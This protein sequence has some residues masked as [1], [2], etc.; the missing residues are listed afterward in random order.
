M[1]FV[2][3][4]KYIVCYHIL[5]VYSFGNYIGKMVYMVLL[6]IGNL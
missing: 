4:M 1:H 3:N 2:L 6:I 5:T